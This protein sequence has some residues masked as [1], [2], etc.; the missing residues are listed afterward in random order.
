MKALAEAQKTIDTFAD[1]VKKE[2]NQ[3][4]KE[5]QKDSVLFIREKTPEFKDP[6]GDRKKLDIDGENGDRRLKAIILLQRL[7]R[8]RAQ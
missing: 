3:K 4:E 7:M 1:Q 8:G 6:R 5:E 2:E